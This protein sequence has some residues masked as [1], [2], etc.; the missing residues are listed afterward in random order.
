VLAK[1]KNLTRKNLIR[2]FGLIEL[3]ITIALLGILTTLAV[4]NFGTWIQN[5][6]TRS[7]AEALQNGIRL[8]QTEAIKLSESTSFNITGNAWTVTAMQRG[9]STYSLDTTIGS[10]GIIHNGVFP[11]SRSISISTAKDF[12]LLTTL[13]FNS[14]GRLVS[15][16][17]N[18]KYIITNSRGSRRF[19][20]S[21]SIAG[22]VRMCDPYKTLSE[23]N[24]DGVDTNGNC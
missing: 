4:N 7:V 24:P 1:Y 18:V 11:D 5:S 21:V 17:N 14:M 9:N 22:R 19:Q 3:L 10:A 2:G 15:P 23:S 13:R 16:T 8:A 20:V 6:Q 12:G